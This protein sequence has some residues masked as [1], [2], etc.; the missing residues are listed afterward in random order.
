VAFSFSEVGIS[1]GS[2]LVST[3]D[4]NLKAQVANDNQVHF[5]DNLMS[6]SGA[7]ILIK[8]EHGYNPVSLRGPSFWTFNGVLLSDIPKQKTFE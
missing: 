4:A 1:K 6:L 5:R 7:A 3:I 8:K 2:E